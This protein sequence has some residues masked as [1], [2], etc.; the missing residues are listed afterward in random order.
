M[1]ASAKTLKTLIVKRASAWK[2][3]NIKQKLFVLWYINIDKVELFCALND[4]VSLQTRCSERGTGNH[5]QRICTRVYT[6]H[7]SI[8]DESEEIEIRLP[9][10]R[11][12]TF[13]NLSDGLRTEIIYLWIESESDLD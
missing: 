13:W 2:T 9:F 11:S 5:H 12:F 1:D 8:F 3:F 10:Y 4:K 7:W 6:K